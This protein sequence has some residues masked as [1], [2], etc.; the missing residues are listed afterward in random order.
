M[1]KYKSIIMINEKIT[2]NVGTSKPTASKKLF[3]Y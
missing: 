3:I 2:K 1:R